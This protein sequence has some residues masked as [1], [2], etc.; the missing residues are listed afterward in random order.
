[1]RRRKNGRSHGLTAGADEA[2]AHLSGLYE[3]GSFSIEAQVPWL[4][5]HIAR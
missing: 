3:R 5:S 1:M 2:Y 4:R